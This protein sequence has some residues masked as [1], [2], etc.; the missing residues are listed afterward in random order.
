MT[1]ISRRDHIH[2]V[3]DGF[4]EIIQSLRKIGPGDVGGLPKVMQK[5]G[6]LT[7]SLIL[8]LLS[9]TAWHETD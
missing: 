1:F 3:V 7:P 8:L 5:S 6:L 2:L 9:Q 4:L